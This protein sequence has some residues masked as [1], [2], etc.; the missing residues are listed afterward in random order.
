MK[1]IEIQDN[2]IQQHTD[3]WITPEITI[4]SVKEETLGSIDTG[5]DNGEFAS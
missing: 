3:S 2:G 5:S 1:N 4:L